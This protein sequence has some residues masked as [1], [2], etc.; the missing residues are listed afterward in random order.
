[1]ELDGSLASNL[2]AAMESAQRLRN[3][4][5]HEDTI[6]FWHQLL[7]YSRA[8]KRTQAIDEMAAIEKLIADLQT[9]LVARG[10]S[11]AKTG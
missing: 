10:G 4:A 7:A 3:H 11:A 6:A 8:T 1:M 2:Q 9:E 5:V